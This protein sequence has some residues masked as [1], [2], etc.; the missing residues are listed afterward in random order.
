M[1]DT[2]YTCPAC[3]SPFQGKAICPRC[4]ADLTPLM[5][6]IGRAFHLRCQARQALG[7]GQYQTARRFATRAQRLHHTF[8]G[9]SL[10]NIA[11]IAQAVRVDPGL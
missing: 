5:T 6:A 11:A 3:Q 8:R 9:E 10:L 2:T 1:S 4:D 7:Q